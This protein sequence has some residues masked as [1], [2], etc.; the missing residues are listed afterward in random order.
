VVR[1][2]S[3]Q[4]PRRP[5]TPAVKAEWVEGQA[6]RIAANVDES[7]KMRVPDRKAIAADARFADSLPALGGLVALGDGWLWAH[8]A[9][10]SSSA[11]WG[12]TLLGPD[13]RILGRLE[14]KGDATP[15][16]WLRDRVL[17][18][19]K[20]DDGVITWRVYRILGVPQ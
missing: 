1:T 14:G 2:V 9:V 20:D 6:R 12:A 18:Q 11:A 13:G 15:I 8:D 3:V 5:V 7:G 19:S 4:G 10:V 16:A 17:L